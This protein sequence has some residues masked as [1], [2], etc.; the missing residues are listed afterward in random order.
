MDLPLPEK[1]G[2]YSLLMNRAL[3]GF[4]N[5][6]ELSFTI[7]SFQEDKFQLNVLT[8]PELAAGRPFE[9]Q[10]NASYLSGQPLNGANGVWTLR[11]VPEPF[12]PHGFD[13]F[14]FGFG[15]DIHFNDSVLKEDRTAHS[16]EEQGQVTLDAKGAHAIALDLQKG[17]KFTCPV[18]LEFG[19][20][21]TD[22]SQQTL[23]SGQR[24]L[25]HSSDF[26]L[27]VQSKRSW[28]RA[29]ED[30]PLNVIAVGTDGAPLRTNN[31]VEFT[32][33]RITQSKVLYEADGETRQVDR[34]T[35]T[36]VSKHTAVL[37]NPELVGD[38][39][40]LPHADPSLLLRFNE[41]RYILSVRTFDGARRPVQ[42]RVL[43]DVGPALNA[44]EVAASRNF[45]DEDDDSVFTIVPDK[46][47]RSSPY[48]VGETAQLLVTSEKPGNALL[49]VQ[50]GKVLRT[51]LLSLVE[52]NTRV[53][54]PLLAEDVPQVRVNVT[55]FRGLEQSLRKVKKPSLNFTDTVL[56]VVPSNTELGVTVTGLPREALPRTQLKPEVV[57]TQTDGAPA[58]G[59]EV[60]LYAVDEGVLRMSGYKTPEPLSGVFD[61][62]INRL[63]RASNASL[64]QS[65]AHDPREGYYN[66]GFVVGGG[67]DDGGDVRGNFPL[68]VFWLA[69]GKTD[70]Q[71]RL[72]VS[73]A[74]PENL[75][76]FRVMAVVAHGTSAFGSG[77]ASFRVQKNL[78]IQSGTPQIARAGDRLWL[79]GIV[80]NSTDIPAEVEVEL[81][82]GGEMRILGGDQKRFRI[83][84]RSTEPVEFE[85][86]FLQAGTAS[87]EWRVRGLNKEGRDSMT[88][89][90]VVEH[91]TP[92]V[93]E[94]F[95]AKLEPGQQEEFGER[96][97]LLHK[98][99]VRVN[100]QLSALG[101][102]QLQ[103]RVRVL[104]HYPYGCAEQTVSSTLPWLLAGELEI[105]ELEASKVPLMVARG[106]ARLEDMQTGSGGIAY[107]PK[108]T[109]PMPFASAYA[110]VLVALIEAY[111]GGSLAKRV[112]ASFRA[113]LVEYLKALVRSPESP[114]IKA[115]TSSQ[116]MALYAL[117]ALNETELGAQERMLRDADF[118]AGDERTLLALA[119][120][121]TQ[122]GE[123]TA[124]D[125]LLVADQRESSD[126]FGSLERDKALRLLAWTRL[127]GVPADST[128]ILGELLAGAAPEA[129]STQCN[130]WTLWAL[131]KALPV[132]TKVVG[133][134]RGRVEI[135]GTTSSFNLGGAGNAPVQTEVSADWNAQKKD[136]RIR[137]Q[138]DSS[139]P[140]FSLVSISGR[141]E[142]PDAPAL[143]QGYSLRRTFEK[144]DAQNN[145]S[146][147]TELKPGDRV[148]VKLEVNA[149][150]GGAYLAL[151]CPLPANLEPIQTF[152]S[153]QSGASARAESDNFSDYREVRSGGIVCFQNLLRR[154]T[155]TVEVI[156][157]VRAAGV[158]VAPAARIEEMY[159]P[160]RFGQTVSERFSVGH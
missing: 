39:W 91:A 13:G 3:G 117:A 108:S 144:L 100:V 79:R 43:L 97:T 57:V 4:A 85:A 141:D 109:Q 156:T 90:I 131:S 128:S 22:A 15:F 159:H 115:N 93:T 21:V 135:Q 65:E 74:A 31:P 143:R 51:Q 102:A 119:F 148:R 147:A 122:G 155:H 68:T 49:T 125:L 18:A 69:N 59:A 138:N 111:D 150:Q 80:Q 88:S 26:Y 83:A 94:T 82:G 84:A 27:G 124:R 142:T 10:I 98:Q 71:G 38:R 47:S 67:G 157:R 151:Y 140:L 118:L 66:K 44:S 40:I 25:L 106:L 2:R 153:R 129:A 5:T 160:E 113:R 11:G 1:E 56:H 20:E 58:S 55:R 96:S 41:G 87:L 33:E 9:A 75:S 42:T 23:F 134:I 73:F 89:R 116:C 61:G 105:P 145:P 32:V 16:L 154:G 8:S 60:T 50:S 36:P 12:H 152:V 114:A 62:Y 130:A 46:E 101:R 17:R 92:L 52:K 53:E 104:L 6:Q 139:K 112:D 95:F 132:E 99:D 127:G 120:I 110:G 78:Q 70:F 133:A 158:A 123:K 29:G 81:K 54:V 35:F 137:L 37:R 48:H 63:Y 34:F 136:R 121:H 126:E 64:F 146:P 86:E 30:I 149:H 7:A 14:T 45:N 19:L 103:G 72:R 24:V 28:V 107:W 76:Q 77:D